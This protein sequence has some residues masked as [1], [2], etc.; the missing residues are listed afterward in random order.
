[1]AAGE[2]ILCHTPSTVA[3]TRSSSTTAGRCAEAGGSCDGG[4][5]ARGFVAALAIAGCAGDRGLVVE[6][7]LLCQIPCWRRRRLASEWRISCRRILCRRIPCC[8]GCR[9]AAEAGGSWA[10][11]EAGG[12]RAAA[13]GRRVARERK[14]ADEMGGRAARGRNSGNG[15]LL[16][17]QREIFGEGEN[18]LGVVRPLWVWARRWGAGTSFRARPCLAG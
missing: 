3:C 4:R 18:E 7:W 16:A 5:D 14:D 11:A 8:G 10:A 17:G 12:S 15:L 2:E 13:G 1:M 6:L 9:A